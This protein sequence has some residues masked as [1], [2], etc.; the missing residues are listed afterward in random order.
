MSLP[1]SIIE[2]ITYNTD[3]SV[4]IIK[5]N[6]PSKLNAFGQNHYRRIM[7]LLNLAENDPNIIATILVSSGKFFSAG[8]DTSIGS[9]IASIQQSET[10]E[11]SKRGKLESFL[12]ETFLANNTMMVDAFTRHSKILVAALNGPVIGLSAALVMLCDIILT[13]D[14]DDV[15]MLFP[16]ATL[17]LVS[18]GAT[19]V[20]LFQRLG[21]TRANEALL[22]SRRIPGRELKEAGVVV[23]SFSNDKNKLGTEEFNEAVINNMK[24]RLQGLNF[25]SIKLIKKLIGDNWRQ[26][27]DSSNINEGVEG[28]RRFLT[29]IPGEKFQQ[30][31]KRQLK[32][33]L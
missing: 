16:F 26:K 14:L 18:E 9:F 30:L 6:R 2:E 25:D 33:K 22:L 15:Y 21:V 29:G 3:G 13:N 24:S 23:T 27:I 7:D 5:F 1:Q 11:L 19:S 4:A 32:H 17:G 10:D 8:A 12:K 20:T 31:A 28:L